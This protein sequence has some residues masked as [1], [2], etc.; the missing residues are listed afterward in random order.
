MDLEQRIQAIEERNRRVEL[1]K[2]WEGSFARIFFISILT[3]LIALITLAII[4]VPKFFWSSLIPVLG[5]ILSTQSLPFI[6]KW[7]LKNK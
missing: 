1:D 4:Q 3:Y 5:F 6:K 7:W 2:K